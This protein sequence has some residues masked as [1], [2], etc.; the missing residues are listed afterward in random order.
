MARKLKKN[1]YVSLV[2]PLNLW[3]LLKELE[4]KYC[5]NNK[6]KVLS[7][8]SSTVQQIKFM[9]IFYM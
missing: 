9:Y 6:Q 4:F 3:R 5:K 2:K 8:K 7:E 1:I